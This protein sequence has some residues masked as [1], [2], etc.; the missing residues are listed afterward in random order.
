MALRS[1][2]RAVAQGS[3]VG[4]LALIPRLTHAQTE[5]ATPAPTEAAPATPAA[6]APTPAPAD[7]SA[8]QARL[9]EIDQR[10]RILERKLELA[11]EDQAKRLKET[12]VLAAGD[13]GF[14]ITSPDKA[15]T[16]KIKGLLQAD[17]RFFLDDP[18][19]GAKDQFLIRKARPFIDAT[20]G[21]LADFRI[22]ADFASPAAPIQDAYVDFKPWAF[23]KLRAGKFKS[24]IGLER[25]QND[26]AVKFIERSFTSSVAPNRDVGF[27]LHGD[28]LGGAIYYAIAA[29]DGAGDGASVDGDV[30]FA[31]DFAGRLFFQPFKN[32]PY[33]AF[34]GL[35][36]GVA[37]TTGNQ[38]ASTAAPGLSGY[39]TAGQQ[40]FFSYLTDSKDATNTPFANK[41]R[42][43]IAP[44]LYWFVGPFGL[45]AEHVISR[46]TIEKKG[47]R[48]KLANQATLVQ[49]SYVLTGDGN[50]Y[51]GVQ[52]KENFD[53][54]KGT[55]GSLELSA[56]YNRLKIDDDTFPTYADPNAA[57]K[58]AQGWAVALFWNWTRNLAW[59]VNYEQT[60]F[61]GGAAAGNDRKTE[62]VLITRAQASF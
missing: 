27:Q 48:V 34:N 18:A 50:T 19:L 32:D 2:A 4:F 39:V 40:S 56:R 7:D 1:S 36:F 29:F 58:K 46:H 10:S 21:N 24:P 28:I 61:Q 30:S 17:G 49:A 62:N 8:L 54:A 51:D 38:K 42:D 23:L 3:L 52:V 6:P 11:D 53:P 26:A 55:W 25:L 44:Q 16:V 57:V 37:G 60:F 35:G 41:R 9:N 20:L 31:K 15:Y 33:S 14:S 59:E 22:M 43:R 5:P 45:L 12:P 47:A 13:K